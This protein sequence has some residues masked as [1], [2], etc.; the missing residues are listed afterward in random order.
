MRF[1]QSQRTGRGA[2]AALSVVY[3][4]RGGQVVVSLAVHRRR[5][6]RFAGR[7]PGK[8]D[9]VVAQSISDLNIQ[10]FDPL[11]APEDLQRKLPLSAANVQAVAEGRAEV[12]RILTGEDE[13]ML[14]IVGPCSIHDEKAALEYAGNLKATAD[15]VRE[16]VLVVMRVYF[17]KPRTSL[18]WKGFINDPNLDG[19]FDIGS[20][21]FRARKLLLQLAD[22]GVLAATEFLDPITPQYTADL[23]AW[24]AI[25]ARTTESQT[26]R[27]MA[28]G[29]SMPV[30]FKN[31][32]DGNSQIAIDAMKTARAPHAFLGIDRQGRTCVVH[33][34]G[35]PYGRLILRGGSGG[36]NYAEASVRDVQEKLAAA[37]LPS[38]VMVD[39][40]HA[41]S[42]KDHSR[43]TIAFRDVV[44]QR[45]AG[46]EGLVG[47][48][49]ESHLNSGRQELGDAPERLRYGVSITDACMG[50][51]ETEAILLE[52]CERLAAE[53]A[54]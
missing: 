45:R 2:G 21:L 54:A 19:S 18:G 28:S 3:A 42:E 10:R 39:C 48:M 20:G 12:Q 11:V 46:N 30:G 25:G 13:R 7:I 36:P 32:T 49:V 24:A 34:D 5:I 22:M 1:S 29:L 43:Q 37:D 23:I 17:E 14:V 40:S 41:N 35:N 53:P 15:R 26:H 44:E 6:P 38:Q 4:A 33:T 8:G 31:G 27:E 52:A 16:S 50:W 47:L 9:G 51:D